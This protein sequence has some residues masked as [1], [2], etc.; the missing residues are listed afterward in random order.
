MTSKF[1]KLLK[2]GE[3]YRGLINLSKDEEVLKF[4][5][6][7]IGGFRKQALELS[8]STSDDRTQAL[9]AMDALEKIKRLLERAP[10]LDKI[11]D[12]NIE[13]QQ[14]I[15]KQKPSKESI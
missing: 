2:L 1:D 5:D 6:F 14:K 7:M 4:L 10:H 8:K 15:Q 13:K 12:V 9:I 3:K 11:N